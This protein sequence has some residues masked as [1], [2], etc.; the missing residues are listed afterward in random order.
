MDSQQHIIF[1]VP[2][3]P[4][5]RHFIIL[6]HADRVEILTFVQERQFLKKEGICWAPASQYVPELVFGAPENTPMGLYNLHNTV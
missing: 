3:R 1:V 4:I 5:N 6:V 2:Q